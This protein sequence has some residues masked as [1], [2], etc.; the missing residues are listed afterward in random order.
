M[1][2]RLVHAGPSRCYRQPE[3]KWANGANRAPG[4]IVTAGPLST[5]SWTEV[6]RGKG[7]TLLAGL[8]EREFERG[9]RT[10][11]RDDPQLSLMI[12]DDG[13]ANR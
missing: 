5:P 4:T 2:K 1:G 6:V 10:V 3:R 7:V 11:I 13:A 12:L 8:A 9:T